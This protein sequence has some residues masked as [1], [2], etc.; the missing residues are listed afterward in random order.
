MS[1]QT[2]FVFSRV[3]KWVFNHGRQAAPF[4]I[5]VMFVTLL[6]LAFAEPPV[7]MVAAVVGLIIVGWRDIDTVSRGTPDELFFRTFNEES[8]ELT[9]KYYARVMASKGIPAEVYELDNSMLR[10]FYHER[11]LTWTYYMVVMLQRK[12]LMQISMREPN[13]P[14]SL[15]Q[16]ELP[17]VPASEVASGSEGDSVRNP[18]AGN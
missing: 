3:N 6:L 16:T 4:Y 15:Q 14:E 18:D 2:D 8:L 12:A 9:C 13:E 17:P 7:A 5:V 1:A 11:D 10:F